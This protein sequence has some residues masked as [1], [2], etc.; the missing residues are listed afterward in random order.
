MDGLQ[1]KTEGRSRPVYP[2][3]KDVPS[4][5]ETIEIAPGL[6][7]ACMEVP[8]AL[9]W[10]NVWL[11]D[12]G[13]SWSIIDTGMPLDETKSAWRQLI[14]TVMGGE[15]VGRVIATHMHPDHIGLA[16]WFHRKTGAELWISR[17]EYVTCRMLC[18]DTGREA[19][20]V[21]L[22]FFE[23]AGWQPHH[24]A[25]YKERFGRFGM[26][27]TQL[28]DRFTRL[29]GGDE[30]ELGGDKWKVLHGNG[31]SPEHACLYSENQNILISGD[32][33]LPRISSN[34]S[35]HPTEPDADPLADW[36]ASCAHLKEN[37]SP[38]VLVLPGHNEPFTGAHD[39]LQALIDGHERGLE[40][41]H[42][43]LTEEPRRVVDVFPAI[44]GRKIDDDLIGL[45]T[46]EALAHLNCLIQRGDAVR[47]TG[48]DGVDL[49]SSR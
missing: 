20:E 2:F 48:P 24:I 11:V 5:G 34:V 17:L 13:G 39:R 21:A 18:A 49:Y 31:H 47:E 12:D 40:R 16:G 23:R 8:F 45:A 25:A 9:K 46:G 43:R 3:G 22:R 37:T 33:L 32:Q 1:S 10:V 14:D 28:P 35:V 26:G 36:L 15:Q 29:T 19:P 4:P 42:Q 6:H 7:W 41:L 30:I 27:V 44:F 38:D